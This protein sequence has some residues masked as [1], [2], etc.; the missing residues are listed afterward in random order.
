MKVRLTFYIPFFILYSHIHPLVHG[1]ILPSFLPPRPLPF[2]C[3]KEKK[4][5]EIAAS[6]ACKTNLTCT[7]T[8]YTFNE[9]WTRITLDICVIA[10]DLSRLEWWSLPETFEKLLWRTSRGWEGNPCWMYSPR[11]PRHLTCNPKCHSYWCNYVSPQPWWEREDWKGIWGLGKGGWFQ[12]FLQDMLCR[13]HLDHG[14]V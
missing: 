13:Q 9:V 7:N 8:E 4:K 14:I 12:R 5:K 6:T 3:T 2:L 11:S 10:V 1:S